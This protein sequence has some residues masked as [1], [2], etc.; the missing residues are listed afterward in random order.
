M[1]LLVDSMTTDL[2]YKYHRWLRAMIYDLADSL[3]KSLIYI[4]MKIK[5][6]ICI[7]ITT[8]ETI[9]IL[10]EIKTR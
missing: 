3:E 2:K 4:R 9:C 7:L 6:S 5:V 10:E 1:V 8:K